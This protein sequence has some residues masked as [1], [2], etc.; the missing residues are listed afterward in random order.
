MNVWPHQCFQSTKQLPYAFTHWKSPFYLK[1]G[2]TTK[3]N[4]FFFHLE[5]SSKGRPA[6]PSHS[7][8]PGYPKKCA[9]G[10]LFCVCSTTKCFVVCETQGCL[11]LIHLH[12][13]TTSLLSQHIA[14]NIIPS[15]CTSRYFYM[16]YIPLTLYVVRGFSLGILLYAP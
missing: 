4:S 12:G 9:R 5:R 3:T 16:N 14:H 8:S 7:L 6:C 10:R 11:N 1:V 15:I 2:Q 13:F